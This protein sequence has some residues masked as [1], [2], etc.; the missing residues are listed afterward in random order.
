VRVLQLDQIVEVNA[1]SVG[2]EAARD[3]VR[4]TRRRAAGL[5]LGP[6]PAEQAAAAGRA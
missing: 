5:E 3:L 6:A 1:L 4:C 2:Q